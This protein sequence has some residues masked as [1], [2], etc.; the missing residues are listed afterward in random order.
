MEASNTA[1]M[2][3]FIVERVAAGSVSEVVDWSVSKE[4]EG[5]TVV[6]NTI[7]HKMPRPHPLTRKKQSGG[8]SQ[9]SSAC[10]CN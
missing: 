2:V 10:V 4:A 7:G 3:S 9:I 6:C 5:I 8:P 1:R